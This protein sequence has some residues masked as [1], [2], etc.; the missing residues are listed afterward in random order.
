M[1]GECGALLEV[2][3]GDGSFLEL[4]DEKMPPECILTGIDLMVPA[5]KR[6]VG[7]RL[8]LIQG[9]F[10]KVDFPVKYDAV[11]MFGVL[12]HLAYPLTSLKRVSEQLKPRGLLF[13]DIPSWDSI[14]RRLFP[15]H[16]QGLQIPRHQTLLEPHSLRNLLN[17]AGYDV[18]NIRFIYDPGDLSVT[19]C[20]WIVDKL[21]LQT[22]P[23]QTWFYFPAVILLAPVVWLVNVLSRRSGSIEFTARRRS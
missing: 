13:G 4:L 20:N 8:H 3:C 9:E 6:T 15:R 5:T 11:V 2:G 16:W 12:E 18:V 22:P 21:R 17:A 7:S 14:W 10:E 19:L 23:R 1:G